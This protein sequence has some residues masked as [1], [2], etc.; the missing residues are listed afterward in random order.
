ME[1]SFVLPESEHSIFCRLYRYAS[2]FDSKKILLEEMKDVG[3]LKEI[4]FLDSLLLKEDVKLLYVV[5]KTKNHILKTH[6]YKQLP[7]LAQ[8]EA[9]VGDDRI[10]VELFS[11]YEE[12]GIGDASSNGSVTPTFELDPSKE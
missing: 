4:P 8:Q 3:D 11:L 9:A 12:I 6:K 7:D 10:P 5:Q 1:N 2:D